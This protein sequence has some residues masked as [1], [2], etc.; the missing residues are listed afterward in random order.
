LRRIKAVTSY[1]KHYVYKTILPFGKYKG[2][3]V[4]DIL[5]FDPGWLVWAAE[6]VKGFD[7]DE[8]IYEEA[9][10][11]E[12]Q[13]FRDFDADLLDEELGHLDWGLDWGDD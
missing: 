1:K 12:E 3:A 13:F 6:N 11:G 9:R 5:F 7:L 4:E 8:E 2:K 10:Y